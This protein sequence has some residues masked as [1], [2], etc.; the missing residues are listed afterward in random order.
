MSHLYS[1]CT[2][3]PVFCPPKREES[4]SGA[5]DCCSPPGPPRHHQSEALPA[6]PT[7][8]GK[9]VESSVCVQLSAT[10]RGQAVLFGAQVPLRLAGGS[11]P[12]L[13]PNIG[14]EPALPE[15]AN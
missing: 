15:K 10:L 7:C 14:P 11:G 13:G 3:Q 2:H 1:T 6:P 12:A 4:F 9:E 8:R 5:E